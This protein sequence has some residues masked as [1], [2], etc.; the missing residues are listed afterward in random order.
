MPT[1]EEG[2]RRLLDF[3]VSGMLRASESLG[4][5][6]LFL[7]AV[8]EAG[9]RRHMTDHLPSFRASDDI[10]ETCAEFTKA[11]DRAGLVD[12]SDTVF[13]GD[14]NRVDMEIGDACP[15]RRVCTARHDEGL[16]VHCLRVYVLAEM[17]RIRLDEDFEGK[18]IRF[19]RPCRATITR[20]AW[21]KS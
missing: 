17:L 7:R 14:A 13:R 12:R 6:N 9:L 20:S 19:G 2:T 16:T 1:T 5:A 3:F 15:C 10:T 11:I 4:N 21:G 8:V 18:L